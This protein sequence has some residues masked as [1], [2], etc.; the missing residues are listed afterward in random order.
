MPAG[1]LQGVEHDHVVRGDVDGNLGVVRHF[2]KAGI[3]LEN[4]QDAAFTLVLA[5]P[6]LEV[7]FGEFAEVN[8]ASDP[9]VDDVAGRAHARPIRRQ[10]PAFRTDGKHDRLAR[11]QVPG[12]VRLPAGELAQ[13]GTDPPLSRFG[14][15]GQGVPI[16][17]VGF[18]DEVGDRFGPWLPVDF[19]RGADL[20]EM[21]LVEDR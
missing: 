15:R 1:R 9:P 2:Q 21:P 14:S 11:V 8:P 18:A 20:R 3:Q 10:P 17:E 19:A 7:V 6:G 4:F 13:R 16:Q 12:L 5:G